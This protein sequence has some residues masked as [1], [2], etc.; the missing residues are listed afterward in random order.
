[1]NRSI[2]LTVL[3]I[4]CTTTA[5][6]P[7]QAP[8]TATDLVAIPVGTPAP[9]PPVA[10]APVTGLR[11]Q[12]RP[13][14]RDITSLRGL[15]GAAISRDGSHVAYVVRVPSFDPNA[16]P[17]PDDTKGGWKVE[18]QLYVIDRAGG[19]A[20]QLTFGDDPVNSPRFSPDG[21]SIAFLRK[22]GSKPALQVIALAGGEPR[23][24]AVGDYEIVSTTP[25]PIMNVR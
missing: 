11:T 5:P 20:V 12:T 23:I 17:A 21:K 16:K 24:V 22:H 10:T 4:G 3:L 9:W 8:T 15:R 2:P 7:V 13:L 25:A 1:V 6:T 14:P 18:Q 19:T